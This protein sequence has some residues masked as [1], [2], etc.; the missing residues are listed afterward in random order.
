MTRMKET[1]CQKA[2]R[3]EKER[4]DELAKVRDEALEEAAK[5]CEAFYYLKSHELAHAIRAIKGRHL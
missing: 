3:L 4:L 1:S 2:I 5:R